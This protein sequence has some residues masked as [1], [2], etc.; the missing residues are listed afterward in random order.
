MNICGEG[1]TLLPPETIGIIHG[2]LKNGHY[3]MVVTNGTVTKRFEE[4]AGLPVEYLNRLL[5][6]FS[7]HYLELKRKGLFAVFFDNV[8]KIRNA[9]CS[10]S[11]EL[12]P[13]DEMIP[14]IDDALSL[15]RKHIGA[16]CHVTVTRDER[17]PS[18]S[19]LTQQSRTDYKN[20][21]NRFQS[22][23]F[24]FKMQVFGEKR[25]EYCYAGLWSG[26]L[27]LVSGELR[28][29]YRGELLQNIFKDIERPIRY[30]PVGCHCPEPHCYNAHAYMT[31]GV[32]PSIITP[33]FSKMRNRL[34]D[35]GS[36]WLNPTMNSFLKSKLREENKELNWTKKCFYELG[37]MRRKSRIIRKLKSFL[38]RQLNWTISKR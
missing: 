1:E 20:T 2:I 27:D 4:I 26:V 34:C 23:L 29:C 7:F 6:K 16:S 30:A 24:K 19:I 11:L 12:T 36:E 18:L 14:Y 13:S 15:C 9:G 10:I 31:L 33:E 3:A 21:W 25:N 17:N 38:S 8:K 37:R 32:T 35:D 5:I 28:Q 22:D